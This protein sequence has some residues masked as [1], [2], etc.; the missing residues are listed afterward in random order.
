MGSV[1][2]K[3]KVPGFLRSGAKAER[4]TRQFL[5]IQTAFARRPFLGMATSDKILILRR[6]LFDLINNVWQQIQW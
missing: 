5:Q 4:S 1:P 2:V 6:K 3:L